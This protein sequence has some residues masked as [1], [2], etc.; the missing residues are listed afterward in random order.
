MP[1]VPVRRSRWAFWRVPVTQVVDD[2]LAFHLEMRA[3]RL[4]ALGW[5]PDV[6]RREALR[7][8]PRVVPVSSSSPLDVLSRPTV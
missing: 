8:R 5:A 7:S 4:V 2:E 3:Q 6:A 1:P